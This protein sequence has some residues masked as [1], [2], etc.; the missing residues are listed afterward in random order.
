MGLD[1]TPDEGMADDQVL[2]PFMVRRSPRGSSAWTAQPIVVDCIAMDVIAGRISCNVIFGSLVFATS[3]FGVD[4]SIETGACPMPW[5]H[6]GRTPPRRPLPLTR[7][8]HSPPTFSS[9]L[10]PSVL[11]Q[12]P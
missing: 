7:W 8:P 5:P 12:R 3:D 6:L 2:P 9:A 4:L 1:N 11:I 10:H